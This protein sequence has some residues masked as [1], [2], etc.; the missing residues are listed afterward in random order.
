MNPE[1]HSKLGDPLY[2]P[3]KG[4]LHTIQKT[5]TT[6][7]PS[8]DTFIPTLVCHKLMELVLINRSVHV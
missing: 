2:L 3:K 4:S 6:S 7:D 1:V 8:L 5:S